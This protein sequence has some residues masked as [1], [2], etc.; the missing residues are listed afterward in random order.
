M[1]PVFI[2]ACKLCSRM[3]LDEEEP[4][5]SRWEDVRKTKTSVE[6]RLKLKGPVDH[7]SPGDS[8]SH[9]IKN[10]TLNV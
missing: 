10:E 1:R 8:K 3:H 5:E 4:G 9:R 2:R 6:N 7:K